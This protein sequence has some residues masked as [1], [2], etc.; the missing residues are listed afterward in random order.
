MIIRNHTAIPRF[1]KWIGKLGASLQPGET[2]EVTDEVAL[3]DAFRSSFDAGL[4]EIL[5]FAT[6]DYSVV[7]QKE[8]TS[9][10]T[11]HQ[12]SHIKDGADELDGDQLDIDWNPANYS[13]NISPAEVTHVDHLT[14]HLK[15]ID[16]ALLTPPAHAPSHIRGGSDQLDGDRIDIDWTPS[17]YTR[18]NSPV[19]AGHDEH[20]TAHLA[21]IDNKL[22]GSFPPNGPAGGALS[23]TYPNP[24]VQND[25][26]NHSNLTVTL[27]HFHLGGITTDDHHA[28]DHAATHLST[29][30]LDGDQLDIDWSPSNY[31]P[32]SSI[33]EASD[34]DDLSAHLK[35]IDTK[36]GGS[37]PPNGAAG[38]DLSGTYPNPTVVDN[39]H[40]H[41]AST[42][43]LDHS[44]LGSIGPNDHHPRYHA[45]D[46]VTTADQIDG[47]KLDIDW[48]PAN[49]TPDAT[50]AEADDVDDLSAHLKGIDTALG[51][52]LV[53]DD[54]FCFGC[55]RSSPFVTN[56]YLSRHEVAMNYSPFVLPFN[57]ELVGIS[58]ATYSN[59]S[60]TA[61][62]YKNSDIASHPTPANRIT[63]LTTS[64]ESY[65]RTS[66]SVTLND[67]DR[68][69]VYASGTN[70][71]FPTVTLF[72]KWRTA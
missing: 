12:G 34:N 56:Q 70:I 32:D 8:A 55:G 42:L 15:G 46:H 59:E 51:S 72:F 22:G 29:D 13:P 47:D 62:V 44:D 28:K 63:Y 49:Y 26:H 9:G 66:V 40:A 14:A 58:L 17:N 50:I 24:N 31:S 6:N 61:E 45:G 21:G 71:G 33:A 11:T 60:W 16:D 36:L 37:F 7:I 10:V 1:Y 30:E 27:S 57:A 38:G 41:T 68:I 67:Q 23:G 35:G 2:R 48:T 64:S 5:S 65:K 43:T 54:N 52:S 53:T 4:I 25:S 39:S 18:D 19:E 3:L 20:V 69:A